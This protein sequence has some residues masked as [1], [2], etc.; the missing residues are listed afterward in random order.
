MACA[1]TTIDEG[2][3]P[4]LSPHFLSSSRTNGYQ[5]THSREVDV[6][7][8]VTSQ[9]IGWS[10][11][12]VPSW[13]QFAPSSLTRNNN[14]V[15]TP[16]NIHV[17]ENLSADKS[18]ASICSLEATNEEWSYSIP[19]PISQTAAYPYIEPETEYITL[20]GKTFS[21]T[22]SI[23]SNCDWEV[24]TDVSWLTAQKDYENLTLATIQ[25]NASTT[26]RIGK[27]SL[28]FQ[29]YTKIIS[30]TQDPAKLKICSDTLKFD[31][32]AAT[33]NLEI[34]SDIRWT[35]E[36]P[37]SWIEVSPESGP[38]GVQSVKISVTP[39]LTRT[40]REGAAYFNMGMQ[41]IKIPIVQKGYATDIATNTITF[42]SKGG[43]MELLMASNESWK[44]NMPDVPWLNISKQA[45]DG[46]Y[47]FV[48]TATD[49]ATITPRKTSLEIVPEV[50]DA[51]TINIEQ[52]ARFLE[53]SSKAITFFAKGG[54]HDPV[55]I[56]TD[57][58][59]KWTKQGDWFT[60]KVENDVIYVDAS[61]NS[62]DT[63][64]DGSLAFELTD[65]QEGKLTLNIPI[66]QSSAESDVSRD[67]YG[68]DED[69]NDQ[70]ENW[71]TKISIKDY[72]IDE[73]WTTNDFHE[74]QIE[75]DSYPSDEN[76]NQNNQPSTYSIL[77]YSEDEDWTN[78]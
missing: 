71:T 61:K 18:R 9:G 37:N 30:V 41:S 19:F 29:N 78:Q 40:V 58:Q 20:P 17:D 77:L 59:Y 35:A 10:F 76:W 24:S 11:E 53:T 51:V 5:F 36:S 15:V 44:V 68:S 8:D 50:T 46:N 45:G 57:G 16:V 1:E 21:R 65:L 64:R 69:W 47:T 6:S 38:A 26:G 67:D 60:V 56:S 4:A 14:L 27:V 25:E 12:N 72:S 43:S 33:Y 66:K 3:S 54:S 73:D 7:C 34:E 52:K 62:G 63:W 42:P 28:R 39:N 2:A 22:I 70:N 23:K 13:I 74:S 48:F 31:R 55:T 32:V 49:N 75:T